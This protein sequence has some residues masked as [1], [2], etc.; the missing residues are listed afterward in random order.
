[1]TSRPTHE[2]LSATWGL[3]VHAAIHVYLLLANDHRLVVTSGRRTV[4]H[5]RD[6]GGSPTSYHLVGRAIDISGP[7]SSILGAY[8]HAKAARCSHT[9]RGPVELI[10]EGDHCHSAW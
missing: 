6:V 10:D 4:N 9:C 3:T 1:V 7:R 5:N 2:T 8:R